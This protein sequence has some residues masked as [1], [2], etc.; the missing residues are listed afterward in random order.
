MAASFMIGLQSLV[1]SSS[2]ENVRIGAGSPAISKF[3][4]SW[5]SPVCSPPLP[6]A[7]HS[8]FA[9]TAPELVVEILFSDTSEIGLSKDTF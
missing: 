4:S 5:V 3:S 2:S 6:A 1:E 7:G 9:E 8:W